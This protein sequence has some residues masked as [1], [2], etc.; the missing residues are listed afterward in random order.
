MRVWLLNGMGGV[1]EM[2]EYAGNMRFEGWSNTNHNAIELKAEL[3]KVKAERDALAAQVEALKQQNFELTCYRVDVIRCL[4]TIAFEHNHRDISLYQDLAKSLME[5]LAENKELTEIRA[6][7]I[8]QC[9]DWVISEHERYSL[10]Y[11]LTEYADKVRQGGA[12]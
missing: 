7:A 8:E 3:D 2:D 9:R 1:S 11:Y 5:S 6:E 12:E 4:K 10:S